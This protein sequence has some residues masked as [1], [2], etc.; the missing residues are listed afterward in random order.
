MIQDV[1]IQLINMSTNLHEVQQTYTYSMLDKEVRF[2]HKHI[3]KV[4][5]KQLQIRIKIL[6]SMVDYLILLTSL[7]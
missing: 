2:R 1:W 3:R 5:F 7:N 4:K 6:N